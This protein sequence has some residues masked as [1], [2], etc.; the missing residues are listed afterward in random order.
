MKPSMKPLMKTAWRAHI[1]DVAVPTILLAF[2]VFSGTFAVWAAALSDALPLWAAG[3]IQTVLAYLAFT[4]VH[5]AVHGNIGGSAK[6][7]WIDEAVGWAC[8]ML[9]IAPYPAFKTLHL[10]H[11]S[12]TNDPENDPDYWVAGGNPL[13]VVLRCLTILP[14]YHLWVLGQRGGQSPALRRV[15]RVAGVG[16]VV[17]IAV[18]AAFTAAGFGAEVLAL[19]VVPAL[20]A[21]GLLAFA[22]DWAP[23]HPHDSRG[24]FVD[25]RVILAPGLTL[26]M[27]GQNYHLIHHLWPRVPFYRY[28]VLF[29]E[30]RAE[31]EAKGSPILELG[32]ARR[33]TA[34]SGT[35]RAR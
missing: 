16:L 29:R 14:H 20:L 23:H 2:A 18:M 24:R 31:L 10:R 28:G 22:F 12:N 7:G 25:T 33:P 17:L 32:T 4:P 30:I 19:W 9:L 11:H 1:G 5:E 8:G 26:L 27:V 21:T 6:R 35:A 3:A 13:S 34:P 15:R